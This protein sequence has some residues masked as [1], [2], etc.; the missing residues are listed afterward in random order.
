MNSTANKHSTAAFDALVE[1]ARSI[2]PSWQTPGIRHAIRTV[3]G[4]DSPPRLAD[5]A[6]ALV[7]IAE[8]PSIATPNVLTYEGPHWRHTHRTGAYVPRGRCAECGGLHDPADDH[9]PVDDDR[10]DGG[11]GRIDALRDALAATR[12]RLCSHGVRPENCNEPH[13]NKL[14]PSPMDDPWQT[15]AEGE[16]DE[17]F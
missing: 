9:T 2:R 3:L 17:P 10:L 14:Q 1:L 16:P 11:D 4:R 15:E 7:R 6:Y 13:D 5:I 12:K 8:D